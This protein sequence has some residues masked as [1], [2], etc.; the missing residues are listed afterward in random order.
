M[1]CSYGCG[2]EA[3][4]HFKNGKS[5]CSNSHQKCPANKKKYS[6]PGEKNP[7][8]G[9]QCIFKGKTKDNYKPLK[10]VSKKIKQNYK[11]GKCIIPKS[12]LN[13][14]EGRKHT[15]ETK[16]KI[17]K[18]MKG[19]NFGL[20]RG[21]ISYYNGIKMR[22]TWEVA[23]AS[24]LDHNDFN[25]KYEEKIFDLGNF[26]SYRPDFFIYD[27][28]RNFV[29]LIEVKGYFRKENKKKFELFLKKY[30]NIIVE[31]WDYSVLKNLNLIKSDGTIVGV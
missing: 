19:N 9:K 23:V 27:E 4:Y 2:Q 21:T 31:I 29:K 8:Y 20:G 15:E 3:K 28:D 18:K 25:W 17:A 30:P 24:Y 12:F 22:S 5:C 7:M 13:Y 6:N 16:K 14:W 1:K 11:T 26:T 10:E